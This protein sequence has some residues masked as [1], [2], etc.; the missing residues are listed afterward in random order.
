MGIYSILF[1]LIPML[2]GKLDQIQIDFFLAIAYGPFASIAYGESYGY[3]TT[4]AQKIEI[5]LLFG[6]IFTILALP[7]LYRSNH[8]TKLLLV[9]AILFWALSGC[10]II[11][12]G[13]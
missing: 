11:G 12:A 1:L 3:M 8:F 4:M 9:F 13:I 6:G 10:S 5:V 2:R 7:Y